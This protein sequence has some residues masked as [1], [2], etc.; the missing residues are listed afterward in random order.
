MSSQGG[1]QDL[2]NNLVW[3]LGTHP[4][5]FNY[6][7]ATA[8][9]DNLTVQ[10][11]ADWRLPT[12]DELINIV[13]TNKAYSHFNFPIN[14]DYR[15]SSF[16]I[17]N[18]LMA[19]VNLFD[20]SVGGLESYYLRPVVCVRQG[21]NSLIELSNVD[22][23]GPN[24][25]V[26]VSFTNNSGECLKLLNENNI[27]VSPTFCYR[28]SPSTVSLNTF[29]NFSYGTY[30]KLCKNDL[31]NCSNLIFTTSTSSGSNST[32]SSSGSIPNTTSSSSSGSSVSSS[33]SSGSNIEV[34]PLFSAGGFSWFDANEYCKYSQYNGKNNWRLPSVNEI[35]NQVKSSIPSN[36]GI[37][38]FWSNESTSADKANLVNIT[39]NSTQAT[40]KVIGYP[41][42]CI[43]DLSSTSSSGSTV[44]SGMIGD[45]STNCAYYYYL[46][47][48]GQL[49]YVCNDNNTL[50]RST[51][52][53][54]TWSELHG[55]YG[56]T[57]NNNNIYILN[58]DNNTDPNSRDY[59]TY[60]SKDSKYLYMN[61]QRI[62][63]NSSTLPFPFLRG[64]ISLK[65]FN[66]RLFALIREFNTLTSSPYPG[67]INYKL[68]YTE[69]N[70]DY[71]QI[72]LKNWRFSD[73]FP[74]EV[75]T[76]NIAPN[77]DI[78]DNKLWFAAQNGYRWF[79]DNGINWYKQENSR[80]YCDPNIGLV[81]EGC[82]FVCPE[83][84]AYNCFGNIGN[85]GSPGTYISPYCEKGVY[86]CSSSSTTSS[87]SSG[88]STTTS[89]SS[90]SSSGS[91]NTIHTCKVENDL[92]KSKDGGCKKLSTGLVWN[93]RSINNLTWSS[94][95]NY[96]EN[97]SEGNYNDWRLPT[98]TELDTAFTNNEANTFF[99]FNLN[100]PD[101][102]GFWSSTLHS[103][104][105]YKT[106][107]S[108]L[109]A[110]ELT[111]T[112]CVRVSNTENT[113]SS[114]SSSGQT[115]LS[116]SSGSAT[117]T[118]SSS[119]GSWSSATNETFWIDAVNKCSQLSAQTGENW[120]LPT[121]N[122]ISTIKQSLNANSFLPPK[123]GS[124]DYRPI[125]ISDR[126]FTLFDG[127][128]VQGSEYPY[129]PYAVCIKDSSPLS[130]NMNS[131]NSCVTHTIS[132]T[133]YK[134][135]FGASNRP[136]S[137]FIKYTFNTSSPLEGITIQR[138][139]TSG[140]TRFLLLDTENKPIYI[141]DYFKKSDTYQNGTIADSYIFTKTNKSVSSV[142]VEKELINN[143]SIDESD[144]IQRISTYC[145]DNLTPSDGYC[146][147]P[148]DQYFRSVKAG[149][150]ER[151]GNNKDL[152]WSGSPLRVMKWSDA[153][154]Y[155]N[156]L[157]T[158]NL[159]WRLP[160]KDE[161]INA[162]MTSD[163]IQSYGGTWTGTE[164]NSAAAYAVDLH[165]N[166]VVEK[167]KNKAY[168]VS[169][170]TRSLNTSSSM[171]DT[172]SNLFETTS[173]GCKQKSG[174][175]ENLIWSTIS[176]QYFDKWLSAYNFCNTLEDGDLLWRLPNVRQ[177]KSVAGS[178]GARPYLDL[179]GALNTWTSSSLINK[180]LVSNFDTKD[181]FQAQDTFAYKTVCVSGPNTPTN[182]VYCTDSDNG[183]EYSVAGTT[184]KPVDSV[185]DEV[186]NDQ[187][188]VNSP[189]GTQYPESCSGNDCWLREY[190]C[191]NGS[192][193][194]SETV[195]CNSCNQGMCDSVVPTSSGNA[196]AC[197]ESDSGED[198]YKYGTVVINSTGATY[199][200]MCG[201][202]Q[203]D[204][205]INY[206]NN[207]CAGD[208]CRLTEYACSGSAY[209]TRTI[210]C[211]SCNQGSCSILETTSSSSSGAAIVNSCK[212]NDAA[213]TTERGGCR[214]TG[215]GTV[216]SKEKTDINW[217]DARVYCE[218]L[219][220][221]GF[222]DW[223]MPAKYELEF[224]ATHGAKEHLNIANV[225]R[226]FWSNDEDI[227]NLNNAWSG[228]L[229]GNM[230]PANKSSQDN[231]LCVRGV[232]VSQ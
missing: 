93:N 109:N 47:N 85:P 42:T 99:N 94:A 38:Y 225:S 149:C 76:R 51:D 48:F 221:S 35:K 52:E 22:I 55:I 64:K 60:N 53:G 21:N 23:N 132:N 127:N 98:K 230:G 13:G 114:S 102:F 96:C 7:D 37:T 177:V 202:R 40:D 208:D 146:V 107:T 185:R 206:N 104:G 168:P 148:N 70:P 26:T 59:I 231:V 158:E 178:G 145:F 138:Q 220:E 136:N 125:W 119:S 147:K 27:N 141:D 78:R 211:Y 73:L 2:A 183:K 163:Y 166:S 161:A 95:N 188:I 71:G 133:E 122:D 5:N 92:Y 28:N 165:D 120:R 143:V 24:N 222:S 97:L 61:L 156:N 194:Q 3:G 134:T 12:K 50:K 81:C 157:M 139:Q 11:Y 1:C 54:M 176:N 80:C 186:Y 33:S 69:H 30:V 193:I 105:F 215:A 46:N 175:Y 140:N 79:T 82:N 111:G 90:S 172:D 83:N 106:S 204:G 68:I 6:N 43:R 219:V 170:V 112:L 173:G 87:S 150:K 151:T 39:N 174:E 124:T 25:Q 142:I 20:G 130:N 31:S 152:I 229:Y 195:K 216:W 198:F 88:S 137:Y 223:R 180:N 100:T 169:C 210:N 41:F 58:I 126:A 232:T 29:N 192:F 144:D 155:C 115:G 227:N 131:Q 128:Q 45:C 167:D 189:S 207:S 113:S 103:T 74:L 86:Y 181:Y 182:P 226:S 56:F 44:C 66:N 110:N 205:N 14:I 153:V 218:S 171:C 10:G 123:K 18:N 160:T 184:S 101:N 4:R 89:S 197:S 57:F 203:A 91:T 65:Y 118:S 72:T 49:A 190:Y 32:S 16:H 212:V 108:N 228:T 209:S 196:P 199:T 17:N 19:G 187:C 116:S 162:S 121:L 15:S 224:I 77:L 159:T 179:R 200:D 8:Y 9:C 213:Y 135:I 129:Y 201:V 117:P 191:F 84:S 36:T 164:L 75:Q 62:D 217:N 67:D 63:S 154:S 34:Q 214:K